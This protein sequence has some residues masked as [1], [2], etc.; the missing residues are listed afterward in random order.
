M[1]YRNKKNTWC[2]RIGKVK[3]HILTWFLQYRVNLH[4]SNSGALLSYARRVLG[5]KVSA[6]PRSV[7]SVL[8]PDEY[9]R[10]HVS[11]SRAFRR[12]EDEGLVELEGNRFFSPE[13][14]GVNYTY[15]VF[16][17]AKRRRFYWLTPRGRRLARQILRQGR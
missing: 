5:R 1:G 17:I 3:K 16:C 15:G 11:F 9:N 12:L 10:L 14:S 7:R 4:L 13:Q 6:T 2:P 8:A